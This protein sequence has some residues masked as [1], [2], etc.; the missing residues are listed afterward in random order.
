ME[1]R[2]KLGR[3]ILKAANTV[4]DNRAPQ[5]PLPRELKATS[6]A[7]HVAATFY[8]ALHPYNAPSNLCNLALDVA[9]KGLK[10]IARM[11]CGL[12]KFIGGQNEV[13]NMG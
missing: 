2:K 12:G 13:S 10:G 4:L 3:G 5:V 6:L 1:L 7:G 8:E 9:Y 11:G